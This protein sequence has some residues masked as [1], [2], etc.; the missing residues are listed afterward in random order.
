MNLLICTCRS[1]RLPHDPSAHKR[2]RNEFDW[3]PWQERCVWDAEHKVWV[4]RVLYR[5]ARVT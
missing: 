3:R 2:L 5:E 4:E 1:F